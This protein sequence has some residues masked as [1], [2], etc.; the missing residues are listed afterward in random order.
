MTG[1]SIFVGTEMREIV[2]VLLEEVLP[3]IV[4]DISEDSEIVSRSIRDLISPRNDVEY[5]DCRRFLR[6]LRLIID[7]LELPM[8]NT[9]R[10]SCLSGLITVGVV[11]SSGID[12]VLS[13]FSDVESISWAVVGEGVLSRSSVVD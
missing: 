5:F 3:V 7:L 1:C 9:L 10:V 13:H 8:E 11:V 6:L 2:A 12:K 4:L